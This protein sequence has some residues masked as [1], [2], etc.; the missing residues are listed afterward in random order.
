MSSSGSGASLGDVSSRTC[1]FRPNRAV[2]DTCVLAPSQDRLG[3]DPE[4]LGE[5]RARSQEVADVRIHGTIGGAPVVRFEC[6]EAAALRPP[7]TACRSAG[8]K[9]TRR[10]QSDDCVD[11]DI[12]HC[13]VPWALVGAG[14]TVLVFGG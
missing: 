13:S 10:V 6:N 12:N 7:A 14:V 4:F 3:V 1:P 11:V 2:L 5:C 9:L 8:C